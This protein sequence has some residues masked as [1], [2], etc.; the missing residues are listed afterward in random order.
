METFEITLINTTDESET[1]ISVEALNG[2][3]QPT[4][5]ADI[6]DYDEVTDEFPGIEA[7]DICAYNG[8]NITSDVFKSAILGTK[9]KEGDKISVEYVAPAEENDEDPQQEETRAGSVRVFTN[10]GF[11][12]TDIDI[13]HKQTLLSEVLFNQTVMHKAGFSQDEMKKSEVSVNGQDVPNDAFDY[14]KLSDGD[15]VRVALRVAKGGGLR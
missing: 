13:V 3:G 1:T 9:V 2:Q 6:F 5:V 7:N 4:T 12:E 15:V 8:E 14:Y 10:G 11:N